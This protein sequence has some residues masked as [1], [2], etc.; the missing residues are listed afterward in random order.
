MRPPLGVEARPECFT[1]FPLSPGP[2]TED[3]SGQRR[4]VR[5]T[6]RAPGARERGARVGQVDVSLPAGPPGA[7]DGRRRLGLAFGPAAAAGFLGGSWGHGLRRGGAIHPAVQGHPED[8]E[9]RGLLD[10]RMSGAPGGQYLTN[11][12]LVG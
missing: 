8:S 11:P 5:V 1:A 6:A 7:R 4:H 9:R 10:L 12:L 3:G 2:A